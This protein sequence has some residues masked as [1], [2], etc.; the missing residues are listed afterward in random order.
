LIFV[1]AITGTTASS[2]GGGVRS[3]ETGTDDSTNHDTD[4]LDK[5]PLIKWHYQNPSAI[6]HNS[7][8]R[9]SLLLDIIQ[10]QLRGRSVGIVG[11]NATTTSSSSSSPE[12]KKMVIVLHQSI[13][14]CCTIV[15]VLFQILLLYDRGYQI[16]RYP[17][18]IILGCT[19]GWIV[20]ACVGSIRAMLYFHNQ[21]RS[22]ATS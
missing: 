3:N 7:M 22:D 10:Q 4:T 2:S 16:Q 8:I 6:H 13:I 1:D 17:I 12:H 14:Y 20:G 15:T 18:P 19:I 11:T 9:I 5:N 21:Q